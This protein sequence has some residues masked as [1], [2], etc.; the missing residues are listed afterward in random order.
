MNARARRGSWPLPPAGRCAPPPLPP[1]RPASLIAPPLLATAAHEEHRSDR[2]RSDH[3]S[4]DIRLLSLLDIRLYVLSNDNDSATRVYRLTAPHLLVAAAHANM[5]RIRSDQI[6]PHHS[7]EHEGIRLQ[8][9]ITRP[10]TTDAQEG[11]EKMTET[12][13]GPGSRM[14][15]P[16]PSGWR[17]RWFE[18]RCVVFFLRSIWFPPSTAEYVSIVDNE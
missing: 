7:V 3:G 8:I 10:S 14:I 5:D 13:T 9:I 4:E 12:L 16:S 11:D 15:C 2:N 6:R 1:E 17:E 18:S